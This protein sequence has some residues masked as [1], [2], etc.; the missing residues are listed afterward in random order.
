MNVYVLAAEATAYLLPEFD[1]L[2]QKHWGGDYFT[3]ISTT[4]LNQWSDGVIQLLTGIDDEYV[5]I[6][7]EDFFLTRDVDVEGIRKLWDYTVEN[8]VDRASLL[9]N[10][11]PLRT[12]KEREYWRYN[13]AAEYQFSFEASIQKRSFLLEHLKKGQDPWESE[14]QAKVHG[15]YVIATE[16]PLIFYQ[17]ALR[18]GVR[19]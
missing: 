18:R 15:A 14:T 6:L 2:Y 12:Y 10:H 17:D 16:E 9:G 4:P 7:H 8:K 19:Q 1:E 13:A 5:I 3:W 11:T